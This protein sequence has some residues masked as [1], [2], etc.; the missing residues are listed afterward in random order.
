MSYSRF[1]ALK[2][3]G[4]DPEPTSFIE[5]RK[6]KLVLVMLKKALRAKKQL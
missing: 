5:D 6:G 4:T 3:G 1:V 2:D